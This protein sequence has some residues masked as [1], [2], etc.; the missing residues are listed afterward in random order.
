MLN[1]ISIFFMLVS[2]V[3]A[4]EHKFLSTPIVPEK[5]ETENLLNEV[6]SVDAEMDKAEKLNKSLKMKEDPKK[7]KMKQNQK[8]KRNQLL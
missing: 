6:A 8:K 5:P 4:R 3:F 2:L 7:K 1:V